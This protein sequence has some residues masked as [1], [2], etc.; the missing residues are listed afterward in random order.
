[1]RCREASEAFFARI[2]E[3]ALTNH[4]PVITATRREIVVTWDAG[5]TSGSFRASAMEMD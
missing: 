4:T 1:M 3:Q 5:V 2:A